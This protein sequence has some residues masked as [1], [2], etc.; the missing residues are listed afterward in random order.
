MNTSNQSSD[1]ALLVWWC[2]VLVAGWLAWHFLRT[3]I[4]ELM[5]HVR[6]GELW[7]IGRFV[8][9][10]LIVA[11]QGY[12]NPRNHYAIDW[13]YIKTVSIVTGHYLRWPVALVL[14]ILAVLMMFTAPKSSYKKA[15][16][17]DKLI[18][19]QSRVWPVISPIVNFNAAANNARDPNAE[20]SD[21]LPVFAEAMSPEEWLSYNA[22]AHG[23]DGLDR[24]AAASAFVAQLGGRWRGADALPLHGK[25]LFAVFALKNQRKREEA[26]DLLGRIAR[27][28]DGKNGMAFKP[29]AALRAEIVKLIRDPKVG[30]EAEKICAQHAYVAPAMMRLLANARERGGVLAPAQFL[31]LRG[32]QRALWYPLNNLGRQS[33]HCEAA[34]AVAHYQ[35]ERAAGTPLLSPK[36][37]TAVASLNEYDQRRSRF[38]PGIAE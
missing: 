19:A 38:L 29:T 14:F 8:S 4:T 26:D 5:R 9:N 34:G 32:T 13:P 37:A 12:L 31:W 28:I 25:A 6:M 11:Y 16:S 18:D 35:A 30:G 24:D 23:P 10:P 3:P 22:V 33:F 1:S 7:L 36:V 27:S 17:L 20:M 15:Y 2:F 21:E